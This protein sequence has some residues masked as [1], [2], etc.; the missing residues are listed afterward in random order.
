M[1]REFP[2]VQTCHGPF[3]GMLTRPGAIC[4]LNPRA[5]GSH[6]RRVLPLMCCE[7]RAE[8]RVWLHPRRVLLGHAALWVLMPASAGGSAPFLGARGPGSLPGVH[9]RI[10]GLLNEDCTQV[11]HCVSH[12]MRDRGEQVCVLACRQQT[13]G[14]SSLRRGARGVHKR[15]EPSD[16]RPRV[17]VRRR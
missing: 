8:L 5:T 12:G 15:S 3:L 16:G 13:C 1:G 6:G 14:G 2:G 10:S 11:V 7:A 4:G 9:C 17:A